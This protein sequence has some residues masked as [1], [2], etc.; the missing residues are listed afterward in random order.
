MPSPYHGRE[1]QVLYDGEA[2]EGTSD[3]A[4]PYLSLSQHAE[5]SIG[6]S[7]PQITVP[8]SGDVDLA[9]IKK[10]WTFPIIR[11]RGVPNTSNGKAF[12]K[13]FGSSD[14]PFT[15][16][17]RTSEGGSSIFHRVVGCKVKRFQK[18]ASIY[19]SATAVEFDCEIWGWKILNTESGGGPTYE[20]VPNTALAWHDC[21]VLIGGTPLTNWY[22]FAWTLENDLEVIPDNAGVVT[23]IKRGVRQVTGQI[24]RS[25]TD[26]SSTEFGEAEAATAKNIRIDEVS[27][28]YQ[29]NNS[30]YTDV[31]VTYP[32]TGMAAKQLSFTAGQYATA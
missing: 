27:D 21:S 26:V 15:L 20:S 29:F 30:A 2:V 9:T 6:E 31:E 19:P 11:I 14:T 32:I 1:W 3:S 16:I 7:P 8:K 12:F 5:V 10:A 23:A 4:A 25:V 24:T 17:L 18:R 22:D 28:Q 13:N